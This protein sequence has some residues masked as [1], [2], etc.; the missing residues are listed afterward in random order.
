M[1]ARVI[2]GEAGSAG[3]EDFLV[4][5]RE[6]LADADRQAGFEGYYVLTDADSGKV[7]V[8]SLWTTREQMEAVAQAQP[9]GIR[10]EDGAA[11][12]LSSMLLETYEVALR[13]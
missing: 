7:V 2:T 3:I 1:Y 11:A 8:I 10:S 9:N 4:F 6:Q 5:A 12:V 13:S